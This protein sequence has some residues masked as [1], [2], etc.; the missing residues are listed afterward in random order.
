MLAEEVS[1]TSDLI[2]GP[3]SFWFWCWGV[4]WGNLEPHQWV[5]SHPD[6][7]LDLL[8]NSFSLR[9]SGAVSARSWCSLLP[10]S[11]SEPCLHHTGF[12]P[13]RTS[14]SYQGITFQSHFP[15]VLWKDKLLFEMLTLMVYQRVYQRVY[16]SIV[17]VVEIKDSWAAFNSNDDCFTASGNYGHITFFFLV[18]GPESLL[19]LL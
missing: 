16:Q 18:Q 5:D 13:Y 8:G 7:I 2:T 14:C 11:S 15:A 4:C 3:T 12:T 10:A 6:I 17:V 19:F 1:K 9:W